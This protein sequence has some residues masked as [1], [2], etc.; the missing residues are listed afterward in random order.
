MPS[1]H[2]SKNFVSRQQSRLPKLCLTIC[3]LLTTLVGRDAL[4]Q[5]GSP[6]TVPGRI[7][8]ENYGTNGPG[9][10]FYDLSVGNNGGVYRTDDVDIEA[11][12][13]I[14]GGYDVGWI[15][16]GE[17]LNYTLNVSETAVYQLAFRVAALNTS[18]SIQVTLDGVPL[19]GLPTPQTG[20]WQV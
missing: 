12:T 11:T 17:W 2:K 3:C 1:N 13:D 4:A 6:I 18:G 7:E 14:G 19:C 15:S 9:I 10:S 20:G 8:A 16:A 5:L